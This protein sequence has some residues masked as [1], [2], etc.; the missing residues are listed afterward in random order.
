M[1]VR[2]VEERSAERNPTASQRALIRNVMD[3]ELKLAT[4]YN[5]ILPEGREKS[6]AM[7]KLQESTFWARESIERMKA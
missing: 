5:E 7:N 6:E 3:A 1:N 4:L 2:E